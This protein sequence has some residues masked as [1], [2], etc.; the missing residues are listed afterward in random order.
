MSKYYTPTIEEFHVG[1]E[2]EIK[3]SFVKGKLTPYLKGESWKEE[4]FV[5]EDYY[6]VNRV[7]KEH[8]ECI[9]VKYL[10]EDDFKELGFR[11]LGRSYP[12]TGDFVFYKNCGDFGFGIT[13]SDYPILRCR[14]QKHSDATIFFGTIK[15]KSELK[16]VLE[17]LNIKHE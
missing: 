5:I 14:I 6:L 17:M 11:L 16:K 4:I 3:A 8:S 13:F 1:F 9:R 12:K 10:D 2:Y 7:L 15:N